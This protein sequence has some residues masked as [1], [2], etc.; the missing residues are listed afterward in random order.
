LDA[1]GDGQDPFEVLIDGE[2]LAKVSN[3]DPA[4]YIPRGTPLSMTRWDG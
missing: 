1:H 4:R 3:L 2:D